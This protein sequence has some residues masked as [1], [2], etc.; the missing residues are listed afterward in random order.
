MSPLNPVPRMAKSHTTTDLLP[1]LAGLLP[2]NPLVDIVFSLHLLGYGADTSQDAS[3]V[4]IVLVR[5][6]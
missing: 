6:P 2:L 3:P 1:Q 4:P 5:N